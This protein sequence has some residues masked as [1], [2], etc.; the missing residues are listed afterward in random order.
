MQLTLLLKLQLTNMCPHQND[1]GY[2]QFINP[3]KH[4]YHDIPEESV[5]K[6]ISKLRPQAFGPISTPVSYSPLA[7]DAYAGRFGYV[8]CGSDRILPLAAQEYFANFAS[9]IAT[10]SVNDA[11]HAF[12][13]G[14]VKEVVD[15]VV[16]LL[17]ELAN[18]SPAIS[19]AGQL[20][21]QGDSHAFSERAEIAMQD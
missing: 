10:V 14:H 6:W 12:F 9:D 16:K 13:V 19:P 20:P 11:T 15:A 5:A 3:E 1:T 7:D 21:A 8:F 18:V 4:M 17:P 2:I